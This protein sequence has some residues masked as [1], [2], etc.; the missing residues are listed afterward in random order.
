[1]KKLGIDIGGTRIKYGV[2]EGERIIESGSCDTPKG[3]Y[4]SVL[5]VI[6][7]I[8]QEMT[9][10]HSDLV[11]I[12]LSVPGVIDPHLGIVRYSNNLGWSDAPIVSDLHEYTKLP[13]KAANDAHCATFAEAVFG[14]GK[15]YDRVA[16]FT[17]GTGVGGGF[18]KNKKLEEDIHGA[19]AYIFG[20]SIIEID[21][22]QCNCGRKGCLETYASAGALQTLISNEQLPYESVEALFSAAKSGCEQAQSAVQSFVR[23][24][25]AGAVNIGNILR[26]QIIIIGGGV[27]ASSDMILPQIQ[28]TLEQEVYGFEFAPITTAAA[29]LGNSAGIIGAANL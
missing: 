28:K 11:G 7:K 4:R 6:C 22:K 19:M 14:A 9:V 21:G 29:A 24:L 8:A 3:D 16:M 25:C 5:A 18:V 2:A 27:S 17:I 26:P 15:D 10:K 20:H 1:M 12:G 23:K 13:V